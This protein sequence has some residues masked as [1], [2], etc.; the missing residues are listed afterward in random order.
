VIISGSV[1]AGVVGKAAVV[2]GFMSALIRL[3]A[4]GKTV[5]TWIP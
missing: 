3:W 1:C 5:S 4:I 2:C